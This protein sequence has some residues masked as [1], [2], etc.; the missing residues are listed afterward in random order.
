M[1]EIKAHLAARGNLIGL[2]D[3]L[4]AAS[5]RSVQATLATGNTDEFDRVPGLSVTN[6]LRPLN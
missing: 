2:M 4:I 3:L 1:A 6:W 5:A